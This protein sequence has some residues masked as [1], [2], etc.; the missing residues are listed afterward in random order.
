MNKEIYW[1]LIEKLDNKFGFFENSLNKI[2]ELN[3]GDI[4]LVNIKKLVNINIVSK[5]RI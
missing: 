3:Q 1:F 5:V 4:D 2:S